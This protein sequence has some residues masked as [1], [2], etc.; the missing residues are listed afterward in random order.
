MNTVKIRDLYIRAEQADNNV[1][2]VI[3]FYQRETVAL[4]IATYTDRQKRILLP[5][6]GTCR[7][8][9]WIDGAPGTTYI[10]KVGVIDYEKRLA[11]VALTKAETAIAQGEYKYS[12]KVF[13]EDG[14]EMGIIAT[15][16]LTVLFSLDSTGASYVEPETILDF[17]GFTGYQNTATDGP[18]RAGLNVTFSAPNEDGS[19]DINAT[20]QGEVKVL[21]FQNQTEAPAAEAG[22]LKAYATETNGFSNLNLLD[23]SGIPQRVMRDLISTVRNTSGGA[24]A[25]GT[26][27]YTT[28][29]T[30][31]APNV[32]AAL[33]SD[34]DKM[35]A[36]GVVMESI[37]DGAFGRIQRFGRTE[38][39]LDTTAFEANDRLYISNVTPGAITA[40]RP[41]HPNL[42][43]AVATVA[44]VHA[45]QG[46]IFVNVPT[47]PEG[48]G[49]GT[50]ANEW[51]VGDGTA[52]SKE[53]GFVS[54][55]GT[56]SV[57]MTPTGNRVVTVQDKTHTLMATTDQ[58]AD[59]DPTGTAIAAA[60]LAKA[61]DNAVVKLTGDQTVFGI[62]AF[63]YEA[64]DTFARQIVGDAARVGTRGY[65]SQTADGASA[66]QS[67]NRNTSVAAEAT[68]SLVTN[69]V[70]QWKDG[71][72]PTATTP[73][74]GAWTIRDLVANLNRFWVSIVDGICRAVVGLISPFIRAS[75]AGG[76]A[77]QDSAGTTHATVT[78]AGVALDQLTA[79]RATSTD[80][81]KRLVTLSAADHRALI[82]A[83]FV[84]YILGHYPKPAASA[85][86]WLLLNRAIRIPSAS[87]GVAFCRTAAAAETTFNIRKNGSN[88]GT[89]VFAAAGTVGTVTVT[90]DTDFAAGDRLELLAP[91][92]PDAD[93]SDMQLSLKGIIL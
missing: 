40:T 89:V 91:A 17:E 46:S 47:T 3:E 25:A 16:D 82:G 8:E 50:R 33:A 77:L 42:Q 73:E 45:T 14:E 49:N 55:T 9:V 85:L 58:A 66:F 1:P 18:Y 38:F 92:S 68:R 39:T 5:Q 44:R 74:A 57:R 23:E 41:A 86:D 6:N 84:D 32:S 26:W 7:L 75:G 51:K 15:G 10:N 30:G 64:P 62:K 69:N 34:P 56:G 28:G 13:D 70:G 35:P 88:I 19:V 67:L 52:G 22:M 36:V 87:P 81:N 20:E 43:Q 60:L 27:V 79:S 24:L 90:S 61:N 93:L 65:F 12:V 78:S 59:V 11:G 21:E 54:D 53:I 80:A 48:N 37:A 29:S 31:N 2:D 72:F 63:D 76:L 83:G 4:Y 71:L